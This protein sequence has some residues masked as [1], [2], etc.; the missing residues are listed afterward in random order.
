MSD[1]ARAEAIYRQAVRDQAASLVP[2]VQLP[3]AFF[4]VVHWLK[5]HLATGTFFSVS[6]AIF[7]RLEGTA[8]EDVISRRKDCILAFFVSHEKAER[9]RRQRIR[10]K[11]L[12]FVETRDLSVGQPLLNAV[13]AHMLKGIEDMREILADFRSRL[14]F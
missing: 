11:L 8:S 4:Q 12:Q 14:Q 10:K 1:N 3:S 2:P 9:L 13:S 6:K 7:R 5:G